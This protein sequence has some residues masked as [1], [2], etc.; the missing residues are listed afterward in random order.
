MRTHIT[1]TTL[2]IISLNL[3]SAEIVFPVFMNDATA[4]SKN[5]L[6]EPVTHNGL[7]LQP[8][9]WVKPLEAFVPPFMKEPR[10]FLISQFEENAGRQQ[11]NGKSRRQN[12]ARKNKPK[13]MQRNVPANPGKDC[14]CGENQIM[15]ESSGLKPDAGMLDVSG[16]FG[17]GS[18]FL[19]PGKTPECLGFNRMSQKRDYDYT[20][21]TLDNKIGTSPVTGT[22]SIPVLLV[23]FSDMVAPSNLTQSIYNDIFNS[24]NYL[25]GNGISVSKFYKHNSY[26][27]L[28]ITFDVYDWRQAP[29]NYGFYVTNTHQLVVDTINLFGTGP[30]AIDFTQ[31]DSDNDG[32]I[33]GFIIVHAG[34]PAQEQ[35]GN[36]PAQARI[37]K[38]SS[39]TIQG[40]FYGNAAI[41]P[42]RHP[43]NFCNNWISMFNYPSDCRL[44]IE[45]PVHEFAHVLGLPD[46][47]ELS[48][49]GIQ[50]SHGL[51]GHTVMVASSDKSQDAKKPVNFDMWSK[52]FF[53]W[54][55]PTIIDSAE[56]ANIYSLNAYD[57]NPE[58][59]LLR[60]PETMNDREF[61]LVTNRYISNTSLDRYLFGIIPPTVNVN[62]GLDIFHVDEAYID[63][64]YSGPIAFNSI[65]HDPDGDYYDDVVS[66][67]GIVF[68]QNVLDVNY[69]PQR[70]HNDLY[71]NESANFHPVVHGIF[72]DIER[73]LPDPPNYIIRDTTSTTYNGLVDSG[74]RVEALSSSGYTMQAYLTVAPPLDLTASI[75]SPLPGNIFELSTDIIYFQA[76]HDYAIGQPDYKWYTNYPAGSSIF[77][78]GPELYATALDLGWQQG[79]YTI[80]LRIDDEFGRYE[81]DEVN[82]TVTNILSAP[83]VGMRSLRLF[84]NPVKDILFIE[85]EI[86]STTVYQLT[87]ALPHGNIVFSKQVDDVNTLK[88][89]DV[90]SLAQGFY[91]LTLS[92]LHEA[93]FF[94]FVKK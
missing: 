34:F 73:I 76:V 84:P 8:I 54:I 17:A 53:G 59:F 5:A 58:V 80:T 89:V 60:N 38:N 44:N 23:K 27:Q 94:K 36:I 51:G 29:Q 19:P 77:H 37:Y 81:I 78:T 7:M 69:S 56:Q 72:D 70:W 33:D 22:Y 1:I 32:R 55:T 86:P 92:N 63:L 12:A 65:M 15:Q 13:T 46:L 88:Q 41:I 25:S 85:F 45:Y 21:T 35:S 62:G 24:S 31:Y 39:F 28:N 93:L 64:T 14:G 6:Q 61:F 83:D 20:T 43:S 67:P 68:E 4:F 2:L 50:L 42:S 18:I 66:H 52:F 3:K 48:Y 87:I 74:I 10:N 16:D 91:F 71:T 49:T 90:S 79:E 57:T 82:I 75:N 26:D 9:L 47:Y 30:N 11:L 40:K